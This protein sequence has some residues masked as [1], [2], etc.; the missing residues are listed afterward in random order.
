[1]SEIVMTEI[2]VGIALFS[3][4]ILGLVAAILFAR[5]KLIPSGLVHIKIGNAPEKSFDTGCGDKLMAALGDN[6][7]FLASACG[8]Q[9]ICGQCRVKVLSGGGTILPLET[10]QINAHDA[11]D[12][13]RLGCQ[14]TVNQS[15]MLELPEQILSVRQW[16][17][18][19]RANDNVATFIKELV[20]TLPEG[21]EIDFEP[22]SY[23]LLEAP[24]HH[25][26]FSEFDV[27]QRFRGDWDALDLWRIESFCKEPVK[28]A[29][30][31]A[32]YPGEGHALKFNI[33]ITLPPAATQ[34]IPPGQMSSYL[35][36]LKPGDRVVVSGPYGDFFPRYTNKEMIYIGGGS[37][38][39]PL[40]SH[41]NYLLREK[42][43]S[44]KISFWYGARSRDETFYVQEFDALQ[45]QYSN[46][47]W[48][49]S[50]SQPK[51]QDDWHG[52]IGYIHKLLY[53]TYLK[54]H[55]APE[56][57]EYYICGP[58]MMMDSIIA[59]LTD[60]GVEQ[61]SIYFDDFST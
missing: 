36:S 2:V 47:S 4:I 20:L 17:C 14:V 39:A 53:E 49:V 43:E 34:G 52:N 22:G 41:I 11:A 7:I 40:R 33:R 18:E 50:L 60:L 3:L 59:M 51:P 10:N 57:C 8:G 27:A 37:G 19:V 6:G 32:N 13:Y 45:A 30:T 44:R 15:M 55:S 16:E 38:M 26:R 48:Y 58:P 12:G 35:F 42:G 46:F 5:S 24:A 31:M 23:V 61:D 21:E 1:M 25:I 28:R 9:G 54:D 29:Y 56:D